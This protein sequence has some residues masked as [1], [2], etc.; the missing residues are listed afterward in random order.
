MTKGYL[1]KDFKGL[2]KVLSHFGK[3]YIF[4]FATLPL[5]YCDF[6]CIYIRC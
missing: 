1:K 2:I 6:K 5:K 4:I 3:I